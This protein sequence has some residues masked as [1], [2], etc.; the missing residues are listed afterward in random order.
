MPI[1]DIDGKDLHK[2]NLIVEDSV[3]SAHV[4]GGVPCIVIELDDISPRSMGRLSAFFFLVA[5][6]SGYLFDINPFDQPG[7]E[8]YKAEVKRRLG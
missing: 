7:V 3:I 1:C 4:S 8:V 2:V 5:A 6:Y